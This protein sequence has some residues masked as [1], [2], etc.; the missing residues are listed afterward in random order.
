MTPKYPLGC[1]R[2]A[3][4][5]GWLDSLHRANVDLVNH[6]IERVTSNGLIMGDG[7][8]H[9][10]DVIIWATVSGSGRRIAC[11]PSALTSSFMSIRDQTSRSMGSD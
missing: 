11:R 10:L 4:D 7:K 1:K 6:P 8:E 2:V 3:F 9:E 5:A